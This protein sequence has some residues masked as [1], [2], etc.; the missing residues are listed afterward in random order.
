MELPVHVC[1]HLL[2]LCLFSHTGLNS[3]MVKE[4]SGLNFFVKGNSIEWLKEKI[5]LNVLEKVQPKHTILPL[6]ALP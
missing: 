4:T 1:L 2:S 6:T 5:I 3:L